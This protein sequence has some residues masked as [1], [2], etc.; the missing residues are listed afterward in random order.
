MVV[1]GAGSFLHVLAMGIHARPHNFDRPCLQFGILIF[2]VVMS[3]KK[4][5]LGIGLNDVQSN[6]YEYL[7]GEK[8]WMCPYYTTWRNMLTRCYSSRQYKSYEGVS[9]CEE[10]LK[11]S[12][13]RDWMR[14]QQWFDGDE[15][16]HLDKDLLSGGRR[17]KIYS[18]DTCVFITR[19]L[20]NFFTL[21][22]KKTR[23]ECPVGVDK[24]KNKKRPYIAR[25]WRGGGK[26]DYLGCYSTPEEARAVYIAY[27][28]KMA[29]ELADQQTDNRVAHALLNMDWK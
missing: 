15:K 2:Y 3:R 22:A 19:R 27:K 28:K 25:C 10:W 9:V 29:K 1:P 13:F 5:I 17:G 12:N 7:D 11:F 23:G 4:L 24:T 6:V 18:P 14:K 26:R 8:I 16:K 21:D 20:N